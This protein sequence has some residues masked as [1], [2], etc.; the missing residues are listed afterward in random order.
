M[1][2]TRYTATFKVPFFREVLLRLGC[3]SVS[4][5]S[6]RY[7]LGMGPGNAVVIVPGG[8]AEALDARPGSNDLTLQRR[9][10]FF[11]IALQQGV[12]L[13]PIYSFG[14]N[15]LYPQAFRN[16]SGTFVRR[17]QEFWLKRIGYATPYF[18]GSGAFCMPAIPGNPIPR[19]HPIITVIGDPIECPKIEHP[20]E[21]DIEKLK[22]QYINSLNNIFTQF[23]DEYAP[24][25]KSPLRIIK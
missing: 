3:I 8:A 16:E 1:H 2:H 14:E 7:V 13:V 19:R 9:S 21:A 12:H 15:D 23:A 5:S 20:T 17:V 18:C 10:G 4:A 24:D 11:R 25:R 22:V 6:I